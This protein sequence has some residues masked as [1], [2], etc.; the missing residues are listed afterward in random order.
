MESLIT[1][2]DK[3][4]LNKPDMSI[5]V[6]IIYFDG[7]HMFYHITWYL[8]VPFT[9][10]VVVCSD[11]NIVINFDGFIKKNFEVSIYYYIRHNHGYMDI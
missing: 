1:E 3:P 6:W 5:A 8:S 10:T 7:Y 9:H 4:M 2:P 11:F